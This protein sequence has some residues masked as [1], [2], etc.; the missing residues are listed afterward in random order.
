M[1][2]RSI[3]DR[4]NAGEKILMDGGTGSEVQRRG[5][6]VHVGATAETDLQC[7]S[8]TSNVEFPDVVQQ[9]HQDYIRCGAELILS[10]NFWTTRSRLARIGQEDR[11]ADYARAGGEN[12]VA[13]RDRQNPEAY[14][15]G[16]FAP[17]SMVRVSGPGES[18]V[19]LMGRDAFRAEV[20][21]QAAVL[22]DT[23]I[24]IIFPEFVG[25]I[26][27]C[28]EMVDVCSEFDLPLFLSVRTIQADGSMA[29][30]ESLADLGR[31]LEGMKV[32]ALMLMCCA[33]ES[34]TAG[35]P[36]L[37]ETYHGPVGGYANIGY[38]PMAPLGGRPAPPSQAPRTAGLHFGPDIL[39]TEGYAPSQLAVHAADWVSLGAQIIGGCCAT[40]PEHIM[41]M[42]PLVEGS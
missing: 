37:R 20:R 31:A 9:V 28:V 1:P 35:L 25:H 38:N 10:N 24:D 33:P 18:D 13:A 17:P 11:W 29:N 39:N 42:R 41:A 40:G 26:K 27:D 14:V 8:A 16:A 22:V 19:E 2:S 3:V 5:A 23:G 4:L 6:N 30:G 15:A 36:I 12:A 21:E 34:I 7:W 32:D